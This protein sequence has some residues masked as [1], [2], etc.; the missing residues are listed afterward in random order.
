[1]TRSKESKPKKNRPKFG[2]WFAALEYSKQLGFGFFV[3]YALLC[4]AAEVSVLIN[5]IYRADY[6]AIVEAVNPVI[7][8]V[9]GGYFGKAGA[10]NVQKI[11]SSQ[12]TVATIKTYGDD[13]KT[14]GAG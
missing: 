3:L 14:D 6:L 9:F 13:N 11:K 12:T 2:K 1:M 4:L 5:P 8:L 7:M 10:E